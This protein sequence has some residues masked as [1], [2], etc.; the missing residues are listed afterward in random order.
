MNEPVPSSSTARYRLETGLE[1][2]DSWSEQAGQAKKNAIY[3]ALFAM[4]DGS[5][6][7]SYRVVDDF[8]RPSELFVIVKDD[9]VLKICFNCF[10]SF[11]IVYIGSG[12]AAPGLGAI[13]PDH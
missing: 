7:H 5:L 1:V 10:D 11:G 3:R 13:A 6:F 2:L 9:L 4:Q 8:Q 12:A